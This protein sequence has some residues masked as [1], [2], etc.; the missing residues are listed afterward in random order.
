[1]LSAT[2]IS[3]HL[4]P[5]ARALGILNAPLL[6][7]H[8]GRAWRRERIDTSLPPSGGEARCV[9]LTAHPQA[10]EASECLAQRTRPRQ[11]RRPKRRAC[12][13]YAHSRPRGFGGSVVTQG[14]CSRGA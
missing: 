8:P 12:P 14:L 3:I 5:Y 1:M 10:T 13:L 6:G 11:G 7:S 2:L 4:L 9:P